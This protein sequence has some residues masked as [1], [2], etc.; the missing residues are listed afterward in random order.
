[1]A[2]LLEPLEGFIAAYMRRAVIL[3]IL[4][5]II[6]PI[7]FVLDLFS[8]DATGEAEMASWLSGLSMAE[9][10]LASVIRFSAMNHNAVLLDAIIKL[11]LV[12]AQMGD[13]LQKEY[14]KQTRVDEQS[15]DK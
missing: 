4:W 1:M 13:A 10:F 6:V 5:P 15:E 7:G 8:D 9:L 14:L 2:L 3:A 11:T 12:N